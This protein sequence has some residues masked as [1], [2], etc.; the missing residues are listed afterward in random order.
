MAVDP[1]M[2]P[3]PG[4]KPSAPATWQPPTP[5]RKPA[6]EAGGG[7]PAAGSPLP[8]RR[9]AAPVQAPAIQA[10]ANGE[11]VVDAIR[12]VAGL[13]GHSF[14]TLL[15]QASQESGLDPKA[16]NRKSTATGPFQFVE[17]TWLDL[18][19]RH[20]SAFGL[21]DVARKI[22]VVDGA[23]SVRDPAVRKQILALREDPNLSAGMAAR[24]LSEGK[25]RLGK[26]LGRPVTTIE[27]RIAYIMGTSG[28]A[29]LI[30]AAEKTPG[31]LARDVLPSAASANRNLF[32][33]RSGHALSASAMVGRLTRRMQADEGRFAELEGQEPEP[34]PAPSH[35]NS[36][37]FAQL[38]DGGEG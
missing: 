33:D 19:R 8:G 2:P 29:R 20:G 3:V 16:R 28:A 27:S 32:H 36:L 31:T 17:R 9:P 6:T 13:S 1:R 35:S 37:L 23:P 24:H 21:G 18:V 34:S 11:P 5:A 22:A 38:D 26:L 30:N 7:T 10:Q 12:S 14:A 25:E 15:S 4:R